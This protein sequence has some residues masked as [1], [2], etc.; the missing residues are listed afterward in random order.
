MNTILGRDLAEWTA[1]YPT[2]KTLL[3]CE[4]TAW[5]NPYATAA[6]EGLS[7]VGLTRADIEDARDRLKRWAPYL[8]QVFPAARPTGGILESPLTCVPS[9]KAQLETHYGITIPGQLW[10]CLLYTS[11]SP[12][13]RTRSRMP[14]SA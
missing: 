2:L 4:E 8:A 1:T 7:R 5:F 11:P 13:D 6:A 9:F 12:R 3:R 10:A 14:S